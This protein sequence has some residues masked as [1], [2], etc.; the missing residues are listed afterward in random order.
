MSRIESQKETLNYVKEFGNVSE[1][2]LRAMAS[3]SEIIEQSMN[4]DFYKNRKNLELFTGKP[5]IP[6]TKIFVQS[7][8]L[9][10]I[11]NDN[12]TLLNNY[13]KNFFELKN[14][15]K[16][17]LPFPDSLKLKDIDKSVDFYKLCV[18]T[19]Q[20]ILKFDNTVVERY[21]TFTTKLNKMLVTKIT[22][23]KLKYFKKEI[24]YIQATFYNWIGFYQNRILDFLKKVFPD[25]YPD[26]QRIISLKNTDELKTIKKGLEVYSFEDDVDDYVRD[27]TPYFHLDAPDDQKED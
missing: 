8:Q 5:V 19:N 11:H 20:E 15:A 6:T 23:D 4:L 1:K 18:K 3:N 7:K 2:F 25:N 27:L 12:V 17:E 9:V 13:C 16:L 14:V 22:D 10:H 21:N 26:V 24:P